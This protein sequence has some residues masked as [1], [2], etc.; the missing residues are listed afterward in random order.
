MRNGP[1]ILLKAPI[2]YPG[3]K[4]RGKYVYEH[5]LVWWKCKGELIDAEDVVHHINGNKHDNRIENLE[6]ISRSDHTSTMQGLR[7]S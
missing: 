2:D 1:Y 3:K 6:K 4:Y 5:H 7:P